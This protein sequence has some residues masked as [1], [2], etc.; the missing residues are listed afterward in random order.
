[1]S[2]GPAAAAT[3]ARNRICTVASSGSGSWSPAIFSTTL[4]YALTYFLSPYLFTT[5]S[6]PWWRMG[7]HIL[8]ILFVYD[9]FYYLMHRFPFHQWRFMMR[10][11]A[12][13][14]QSHRP[15]P[16]H[17]MHLHPLENFLGIGLLL[18][19][20]WLLGPVHV[21]TFAV[22]FFVYSWLNIVTH[23]GMALPIPYLNLLAVKHDAHHKHMRAGNFATLSPLPDIVFGTA[24]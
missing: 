6:S 15:I 4:V 23:A 24:E 10:I 22:C 21:Y 3:R 13:H 19:T 8:A 7:L 17:A 12:V 9:L 1:M 18:F 20:T 11:H 14:H 5:A 16:I 2:R